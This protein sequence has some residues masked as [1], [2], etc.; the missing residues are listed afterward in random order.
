MHIRGAIVA[1]C[2]YLQDVPISITNQPVL[3]PTVGFLPSKQAARVRLPEDAKSLISAIIFLVFCLWPITRCRP[4]SKRRRANRYSAA[5][6]LRY[7]IGHLGLVLQYQGK[8]RESL[9]G[10]RAFQAMRLK[11]VGSVIAYPSFIRRPEGWK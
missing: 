11:P 6:H 3:G 2:F 1:V 10:H 9:T 5:L 8:V 7:S 4:E